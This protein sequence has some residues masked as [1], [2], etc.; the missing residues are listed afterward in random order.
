MRLI[1]NFTLNL[2]LMNSKKKL[3]TNQLNVYARYSGIA[4]QMF[5]I[6]GIGTFIGV[7][8]DKAFPN[9]HNIYTVILSLGSVIISIWFVIRSIV[10]NSKKQEK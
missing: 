3:N 1:R 8:L 7:K 5:A 9:E 4:F 6:I 2:T 10:L